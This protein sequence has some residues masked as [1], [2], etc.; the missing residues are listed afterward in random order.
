MMAFNWSDQIIDMGHGMRLSV[1]LGKHSERHTGRPVLLLLHEALGCIAMWKDIPQQLAAHTGCDVVVY[2]RQG[3]GLSS[4]IEL[5][6]DDDYL[7]EEGE[8]WLPRLID[9]LKLNNVILL[10]HSDG[11]SVALIGAASM[12]GLVKGVITEAAHIYIDHLTTAGITEAVERYETSDLKD[13]LAK[14][15]GERTDLLF[16]AWHE[17][18]LRERK[19]PMNLRPWLPRIECPALIIQGRED[20]YGVPEQVTDICAG[21]GARAESLFL[22][23]CGHVP[24]FEARE[25][26]ISAVVRFI[27]QH[28][29][30]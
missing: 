28:N 26:V 20:Y 15:H 4:T 22:P 30:A 23:D 14:Y 1:R 29:S 10:G 17:T 12:P 18:W 25:K 24:H 7:L 5:P 27:K 21:I 9:K 3:Y 6:R 11:G 8:V 19:Q 16:R 13:K 2:E